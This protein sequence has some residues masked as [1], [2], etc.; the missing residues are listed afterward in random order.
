MIADKVGE[1]ARAR[2]AARAPR[3]HRRLRR[4]ARRHRRRAPAPRAPTASSSCPWAARSAPR[5]PRVARA[6]GEL[7]AFSDANA[8]WEPGALRAL[9]P[10]RRPRGRLRLRPGR[11]RL[12]GRDAT[13]R[14]CTGATRWRSAR[15]SP[16]WPRSRRATARS[17][18]C[19]P[20]AYV[21]VDPVMGHDLTLPFN[22]RQARLAGGVRARGAGER[23]DGP[24]DRGRVRPQAPDDEPH[25]ADRPARRAALA[26]RLPAALRAD[27]RLAPRPALRR[28]VPP[29]RRP[30]GELVLRCRATA[31]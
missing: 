11:V 15:S 27:D 6:R 19:A 21:S 9:A 10:V 3:G 13:R 7:L 23:E 17:T 22:A 31:R 29:R 14:G 4:L 26:P 20:E 24:D 5:T 18:P 12:R 30:G 2:L 28:A 25:V 8:R 16:T 1:R